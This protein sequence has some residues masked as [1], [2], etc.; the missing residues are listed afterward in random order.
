MTPEQ[1]KQFND[2]GCASACVILLSECHQQPISRDEFAARFEAE[3]YSPKSRYGQLGLVGL[4]NIC[5]ALGLCRD[6]QPIRCLNTVRGMVLKDQTRGVFL[7]TDRAFDDASA[8][9]FHFSLV[10]G[11]DPQK[12]N[13]LVRTPTVAGT[14]QDFHCDDIWLDARLAHFLVLH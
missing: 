12:P 1:A 2:F 13:W 4:L 6:M 14:A 10:L 8:P 9:H 3:F 7:L 11:C 5:M